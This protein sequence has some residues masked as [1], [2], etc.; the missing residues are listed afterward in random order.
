MDKVNLHWLYRDLVGIGLERRLAWV[1]EN[2]RDAISDQYSGRLS[3]F[4][5]K[6]YR[7]ASIVLDAFLKFANDQ[8]ASFEGK[9]TFTDVLDADIRSKQTLLKVQG[10]S[11]PISKKWG[12][13][14]SLQLSDFIHALR[15]SRAS[16]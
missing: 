11:S 2:V 12:I 6:L 9:Q 16:D 8:V 4:W 5:S 13:V 10:S 15:G 1:V 14:T 7:R 3:P